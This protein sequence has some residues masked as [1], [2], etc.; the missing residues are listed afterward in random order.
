VK[1]AWI[2]QHAG[3]FTVKRMCQ[4]LSV[5]RS[6]YYAW[7]DRPASSRRLCRQMRA[8]Q[9]RAAYVQSRGVYGSPRIAVTLKAQG[10]MICLNTVA[11]LMREEGLIARRKRRFVPRTTESSHGHPIAPNHLARRFGVGTDSDAAARMPNAVWAC[12]LTYLWTEQGW[13]YLWVVLDLFSRKI[14]GWAMTEHLR[15]QGA[16][17]A[18]TMALRRRRPVE[19]LLHHSDRGSQYACGD[20]RQLLAEHGITASMSRSGNCYDNAVV[21]SFFSTLKTELVH[22]EH[23]ASCQQARSSLFEWIEVFYN[24]QRRHS[25]L[26]YLSPEAF[27][28]QIT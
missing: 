24:R 17:E 11:K 4:L 19:A 26:N 6:G 13:L 16:V 12:D 21:E 5:S 18:L 10:V 7:R 1:F 23:Y 3:V 8:Q 28:A 14:V 20:Y 25:S 27:E 2:G 15:S 22:H 9:V